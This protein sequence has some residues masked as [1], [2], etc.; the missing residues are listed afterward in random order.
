MGLSV[1]LAELSYTESISLFMT[2]THIKSS[3]SHFFTNMGISNTI[4][5]DLGIYDWDICFLHLK[6]KKQTSMVSSSLMAV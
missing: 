3:I 6:N 2:L 1:F 4:R 5:Y